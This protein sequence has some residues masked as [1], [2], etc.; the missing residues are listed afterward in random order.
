MNADPRRGF[1]HHADFLT[2]VMAESGALTRDHIRDSRLRD[3]AAV[4]SDQDRAAGG[5]AFILPAAFTPAPLLGAAGSDELGW[6]NT[7][8]GAPRSVAPFALGAPSEGDPTAG[9]TLPVPM[10]TPTFEI[11]A[12]TDKDHTTSVSG[13]FTFTRK[14]E[15]VTADDSRG[16]IELVSL[17]ATTLMGLNFATEEILDSSPTGFAAII[18]AAFRDEYP[19]HMLNEKIRG[20]GGNEYL[21][22]L[23]SPAKITVAKESGQAADTINATNVLKM[24]ARCWGLNQAIW[25]ANHD[26]RPQLY[27]L[28]L[29]VGTGGFPIYIPSSVY[30]L[31]DMML[32]APVFY[33]ERASALGD[34]GDLML[35]NWS[36]YLE[37]TYQPLQTA[38]S[39]HVRFENH[40]R[41]YKFWTRNAGAPWWRAPLTPDNGAA[42]L[43]P[44]VTLAERA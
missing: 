32:G 1:R 19:A 37:G 29:P 34:E 15:T 39:I 20:G 17:K 6:Y 23:N 35:V 7:P 3:L 41:C 38:E 36:Q 26:T 14:P 13:G 28:S 43:S 12:R 31:P 21:G 33:T 42:E 40:E 2:A 9:R 27:A 8:G 44:I 25:L 11:P 4:D 16:E 5:L 30:G 24:A 22:V 10:D 18:G